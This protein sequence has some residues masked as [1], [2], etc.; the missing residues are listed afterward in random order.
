MFG[1]EGRRVKC[2][3]CDNIW[4][5]HGDALEPT[6]LETDELDAAPADA[7]GHPGE[8]QVS[9]SEDQAVEYE[10]FDDL[11]INEKNDSMDAGEAPDPEADP[12]A[13]PLTGSAEKKEQQDEETMPLVEADH[14]DIG[15]AEDEEQAEFEPEPEPKPDTEDIESLASTKSDEKRSDPSVIARLGGNARQLAG[16]AATIVVILGG[17]YGFRETIVHA[18][19]GAARVYALVG[20]N[21]N[22]R[23]LEF[24]DI[25]YAREFEDG[26]PVLAV[27]GEIV[28]I[29]NDPVDIPT[30]RF[31][32]RDS[33]EQEVY[34]WTG[35]AGGDQIAPQEKVPF[36]T[37]LASPPAVAK[38]VMVR[39]ARR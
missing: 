6:I 10:E 22:L 2:H 32:L 5:A 37:R 31:S 12:F 25:V 7:E 3:K 16:I 30:I 1:P 15:F 13:E 20:I 28:N 11:I 8:P 17:L 34:H 19:P 18:A 24:H 39:F 29:T 9:A 14:D 26:Q 21:V 36:E 23:G 38:D 27:R 35:N 33:R 4:V